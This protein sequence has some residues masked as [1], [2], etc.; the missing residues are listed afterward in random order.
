MG[1]CG[2]GPECVK[3]SERLLS[4]LEGRLPVALDTLREMVGINSWSH[5]PEG[6][7]R[8]GRLTAER[9]R[10]LGFGAEFVASSDARWGDHLFLHRCGRS[11]SRI[12]LVSHLD[13]VFSPEEEERQGFRWEREG[14]R[15][16]GPGVIDIK[17]GTV[18]ALTMLEAIR[19]VAPERF[20]EVDWLVALDGSEETVSAQFGALCRERVTRETLAALV[21]EGEHR[22]GETRQLVVARKGRATFRLRVTGRAA[23]AGGQHGR[24]ANAIRQLARLIERIESM[25]DPG[26]GL[27]MSVGR[28]E[29]GGGLNRVPHEAMAEGEYRCFDP[30]VAAEARASLTALAGEGDVRAVSDGLPCRVEVEFPDESP[31][32]PRNAGTEQLFQVWMAAAAGLGQSVAPE[33]RGGISDG[34]LLWDRV[35]TLDGLGP[36]GDNDH[37]SERS[38]D[39]TKLPEYLDVTTFVPKAALNVQGVL[40]LLDAAGLGRG[41]DWAGV[42]ASEGGG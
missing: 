5:H 26:R 29:G 37:C 15:I 14:D 23:H 42:T 1:P 30:R 32:W 16:F 2:R 10:P 22:L 34:N 19:E 25:T 33:E 21:F 36:G 6:V 31:A 27:T 41:A 9:F 39:G 28:V 35:P 20:E 7:N 17:G 12:L 40:K 24:G 3:T 4:W 38:E 8:L 18:M 13:T 11:K